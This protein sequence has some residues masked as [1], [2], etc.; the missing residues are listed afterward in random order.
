MPKNE[1]NSIIIVHSYHI[2]ILAKVTIVLSLA[3]IILF[4]LLHRYFALGFCVFACISGFLFRYTEIITEESRKTV[5]R[6]TDS[7]TLHIIIPRTHNKDTAWSNTEYIL[8][9]NKDAYFFITKRNAIYSSIPTN[10]H[11]DSITEPIRQEIIHYGDNSKTPDE[12]DVIE[13]DFSP[14]HQINI[15][16]KGTLLVKS[17]NIIQYQKSLNNLELVVMTYLAEDDVKVVNIFSQY[18]NYGGVN[19]E[20]L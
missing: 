13:S 19:N 11:E 9:L 15:H 1:F 18:M 14:Y 3:G 6:L 20:V 16:A 17:R 8:D 2:G 4:G 10:I 7:H 5:V 12:Q